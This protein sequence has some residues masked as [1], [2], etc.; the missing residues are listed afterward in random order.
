M[1]SED[2]QNGMADKK[3]RRKNANEIYGM[4]NGFGGSGRVLPSSAGPSA[5]A[6]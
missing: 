3:G 6:P 5:A 4:I 1:F 2:I